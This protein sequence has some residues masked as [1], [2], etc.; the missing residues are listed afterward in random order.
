MGNAIAGLSTTFDKKFPTDVVTLIF[1]IIQYLLAGLSVYSTYAVCSKEAEYIELFEY[2]LGDH[3]EEH[4]MEE[5]DDTNVE[6]LLA[7]LQQSGDDSDAIDVIEDGDAAHHEEEAEYSMENSHAYYDLDYTEELWTDYLN[8]VVQCVL[9]V[10]NSYGLYAT[11][12]GSYYWFSFGKNVT[13]LFTS[14][15]NVVTIAIDWDAYVYGAHKMGMLVNRMK[16]AKAA[17]EDD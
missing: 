14:I 13:G 1:R 15:A 2:L 6:A 11:F 10:T 16:E 7:R 3:M 8:F 17:M 4:E 5:A 12:T 9:I